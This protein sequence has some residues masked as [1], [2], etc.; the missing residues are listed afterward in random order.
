M[1]CICIQKAKKSGKVLIPTEANKLCFRIRL[2]SLAWYEIYE[3]E[4]AMKNLM[5]WQ[6]S[7]SCQPASNR[8]DVF[9]LTS[10][11]IPSSLPGELEAQK[12]P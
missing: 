7:Y 9:F 10:P 5:C 1:K 8:T 4:I 2:L 12:S 11:P 3:D 6:F